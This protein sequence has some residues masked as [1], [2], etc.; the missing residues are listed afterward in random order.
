MVNVQLDLKAG[1]VPTKMY[2]YTTSGNLV[3]QEQLNYMKQQLT[4]N[5]STWASGTYQWS[6]E[7]KNETFTGKLTITH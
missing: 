4:L 5:T 1:N 7:T 3:Y 6:L 2:I